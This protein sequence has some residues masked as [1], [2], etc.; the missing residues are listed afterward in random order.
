M[1]PVGLGCPCLPSPAL[2][3]LG[4]PV[5]ITSPWLLG[6]YLQHPGRGRVLHSHQKADLKPSKPHCS[7]LSSSAGSWEVVQG[8]GRELGLQTE[9]A[10][11]SLIFPC[12]SL[13]TA[14]TLLSKLQG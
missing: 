9:P 8:M 6:G 14:E 3:P 7:H 4:P 10:F 13:F 12:D 1:Q 2:Q 5:P 11:P